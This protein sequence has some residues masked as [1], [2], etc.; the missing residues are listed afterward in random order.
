MYQTYWNLTR[1]PFRNDLDLSFAF[2]WERYEEA[3][4]RMRYWA[5]DGKRLAVLT[6]PASAGKS[7]LLALLTRDIKRRGDIVTTMPNPSLSAAEFLQ[8]ILSLYGFDQTGLSKSEALATLTQFACENAAQGIRTYLLVDESQ[9]I[10]ERQTF[11]EI[12]LILNLADEARPLFSVVLAGE[13]HLKNG[14]AECVSL[15]QKVEIGAELFPLTL[16]ESARYLDHR[17]KVAGAEQQLFDSRSIEALHRWSRG[18]PRLLNISADLAL[19]AAFGEGKKVVDLA[20]VEAGL[21]EVEDHAS[22]A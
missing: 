2:M 8:Y 16:E 22:A 14:M 20:A 10:T 1:K 11:E 17:L 7:Y 5:A 21:E 3:L 13:P 4:A 19:L 6:G 9:A 18:L 15:R 12:N